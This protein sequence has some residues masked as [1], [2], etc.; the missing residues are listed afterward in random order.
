M[1]VAA[2]MPIVFKYMTSQVPSIARAIPRNWAVRPE[3]TFHWVPF[4]EPVMPPEPEPDPTEEAF[5]SIFPSKK[6]V[7]GDPLMCQK[8]VDLEYFKEGVLWGRANPT[9]KGEKTVD[10]P[11]TDVETP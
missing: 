7:S 3:I 9:T 10:A 1:P 4:V 11:R 6:P 5:W 8:L 2:D